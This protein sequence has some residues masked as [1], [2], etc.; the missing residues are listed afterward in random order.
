LAESRHVVPREPMA[1]RTLSRVGMRREILDFDLGGGEGGRS[2]SC[3]VAS[4]LD[5][6]A[7]NKEGL[8]PAWQ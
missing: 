3:N 7:L 8:L 2:S 5:L 1:E 6:P 4:T